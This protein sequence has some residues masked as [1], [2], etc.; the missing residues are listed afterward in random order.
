MVSV[1]RAPGCEN[2]DEKWFAPMYWG[3]KAVPVSG[4]GRGSAW[5][6][7]SPNGPLVLRHYRRGGQAALISVR[8]YF[9]A[10]YDNARSFA[11]FRL[12]NELHDKGLPVPKPVAALVTRHGILFYEAAIL[13]E[14]IEGALPLQEHPKLSEK[15]L[16]CRV[17]QAIAR[18]HCAGLDHVDLNCDNILVRDDQVFLIDFDRCKL[19]TEATFFNSWRASNLKRL[20]RSVE[21]RCSQIPEA[22]LNTLWDGLIAGYQ[23]AINPGQLRNPQG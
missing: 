8:R 16:W 11:E 1:L 3:E 7:R 20:R 2:I 22:R 12:L 14:R 4:G 18:F 15:D 5:F 10:G 6:V 9:Y 13:I 19:H 23:Q 17:G 21:K